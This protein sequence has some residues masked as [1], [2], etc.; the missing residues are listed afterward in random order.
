[1]VWNSQISIEHFE[2]LYWEEETSYKGFD[3]I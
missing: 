2:K 1:M 3:V